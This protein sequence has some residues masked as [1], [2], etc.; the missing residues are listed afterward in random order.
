[1]Q[2]KRNTKKEALV[3]MANKKGAKLAVLSLLALLG[4]TACSSSDVKAKPSDYD[5]QILVSEDDIYNNTKSTIYDAIREGSLASDVLDKVLYQYAIS[6]LGRYNAV[7]P[8][9]ATSSQEEGINITLKAAAA[10]AH[11]NSG[12]TI[13]RK[14]I[15]A[16]KAYWSVN[17][18]GE[19]VDDN[20]NPV[21]GDNYDDGREIQRVSAKWDTIELRIKEAMY[22]AIKGSEFAYRNKFEE[23]KYLV[24]LRKNLKAV[25]DYNALVEEAD[26]TK[27][28][29]ASPR[30]LDPKYDEEDV[31]DQ[32]LHRANYQSN[33]AFGQNESADDAATYVEDE[34]IPTIYR[35]LLTEQYLFDQT[36]NT[37]GRSY[38]RKINVVAIAENS[39]Y[40]KAAEY[41]MR[42]FVTKVISAAPEGATTVSESTNKIEEK[43]F[44]MISNIWKGVDLDTYAAGSQE[45]TIRD[46]LLAKN[47]IIEE[48]Y[49][50]N[51][52]ARH[53]YKGT[54]FGEMMEDYDKIN[55]DPLL[56][57]SSIESTFTGSGSYTKEIGKEI[58]TDEITLK[59][60]VTKG[61]YVKN[62]SL[63][64]ASSITNRLFSVG[65]ANGLDTS[66]E[67][68]RYYYDGGWKYRTDAKE[69]KY[70]ARINGSYFLKV[71]STEAH[72]GTDPEAS[73]ADIL[74]KSDNTWY[75]VQ[76]LEAANSTKLSKNNNNNY[77]HLKSEAIMEKYVN[78]IAKTLSSNSTYEN[79]A[80][81]YWV[82]EMAIKYH[83][84]V[85]YD[86]FKT[87][88][89]ELF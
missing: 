28:G 85:V 32:F 69:N 88:F 21:T 17:D 4:I 87:N 30:I 55:D 12:Y 59:N 1:M 9:L 71:E 39:E 46:A 74:F 49:D 61:W 27:K 53:F 25:E 83:D 81:K 68:D 35:T 63:S 47:A 22:K 3:T 64:L 78:E 65:V 89:P 24:S 36:Y 60:H 84:T 15:K 38:A 43:H 48:D 62:G 52:T 16:H 77:A 41:L 82:S 73:A 37:L 45:A 44:N 31:F 56:T 70:V 66:D 34:L 29:L 14:F 42:E 86:Y 6:T 58:K 2:K 57:D 75:V 10:D 54:E 13:V 50:D 40:P 67:A 5:N 20:G 18:E 8:E 19:H 33:Y 51:G 76:I 23:K 26:F 11:A 80:K 7:I 79:L 72:D